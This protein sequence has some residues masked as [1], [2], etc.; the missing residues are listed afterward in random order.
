VKTYMAA[1]SVQCAGSKAGKCDCQGCSQG[2]HELRSAAASAPTPLRVNVSG[3]T[4]YSNAVRSLPPSEQRKI[5]SIAR[6]VVTSLNGRRPRVDRI[7]LVGHADTDTPR[8]PAFE[9]QVSVERAQQV[10]AALAS[11]INRVA[12]SLPGPAQLPP[13]SSRIDWGIYGAGAARLVV[14]HARTESDRA[15]NR[16]VEIAVYGRPVGR[17]RIA[18][19]NEF[20]AETS[21]A[22]MVESIIQEFLNRIGDA[23][24][25]RKNCFAA[26]TKVIELLR[27]GAPKKLSCSP[28][29]GAPFAMS[30]KYLA[31]FS[32][33]IRCCPQENCLSPTRVDCTVKANSVACGHCSGT[34]GPYLI[35]G[36][37]PG[38]LSNAVE[39]AKCVLDQGCV[40][41]AGVLSGICDDKPDCGCAKRKGM[42]PNEVWR[43]CPEHWLVIIGY[44]GDKFVFWDSAGV[45]NLWRG[46]HEF[47]LLHY[48]RSENRLTTGADLSKMD[49]NP[50]GRHTFD[51][52]QW[53][54]QVLQLQTG[55]R[56]KPAVR[57]C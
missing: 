53:R 37:H 18:R 30:K 52:K 47:G 39:R 45:S 5:E 2:E 7:E 14:P 49:V 19:R 41:R 25:D 33:K 24:I 29:F 21:E 17:V 55:G 15:R 50:R 40:V 23:D 26:G 4:R 48:N 27:P 38:S 36:Y 43:M 8:R 6:F 28:N 32:D 42:P 12:A 44:V 13:F 34:D 10:R 51:T 11:A 46:G 16:R 9:K 35:V 57:S 20:V 3:F 31:P 1:R 22:D 54:Y 56:Y